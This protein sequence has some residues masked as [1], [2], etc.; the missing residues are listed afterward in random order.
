[1]PPELTPRDGARIPKAERLAPSEQAVM[2]Q[3]EELSKSEASALNSLAT[4]AMHTADMT[5]I[6]AETLEDIK[7]LLVK[8]CLNMRMELPKR[9]ADAVAAGEYSP[10][11]MP[12]GDDEDEDEQG[13]V[14]AKA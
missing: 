14:P 11:D 1:M 8:V 5:S 13:D 4:S 6:M 9:I 3:I 7:D 12:D 2:A 10:D